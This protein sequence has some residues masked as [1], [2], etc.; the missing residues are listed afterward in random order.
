[1]SS[2]WT[3]LND[4]IIAA[5]TVRRYCGLLTSKI[6]WVATTLLFSSSTTQPFSSQVS[7]WVPLLLQSWL[8]IYHFSPFTRKEVLKY[9]IQYRGQTSWLHNHCSHY[10]LASLRSL[11]CY[12]HLEVGVSRT[13]H[14]FCNHQP[15]TLFWWL[16][17]KRVIAI[18]NTFIGA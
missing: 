12:I 2:S 11:S 5:M 3:I 9:E 6:W 14:S 15:K 7:T 16:R 18:V 17:I 13:L 4:T 10:D 1:M 8:L